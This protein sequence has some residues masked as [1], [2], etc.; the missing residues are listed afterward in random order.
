MS[1]NIIQLNED[2]IKDSVKIRREVIRADDGKV[3]N[4][5]LNKN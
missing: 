4:V 3:K 5:C 1:D 2:L